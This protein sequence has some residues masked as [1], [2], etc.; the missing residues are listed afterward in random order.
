MRFRVASRVHDLVARPALRSCQRRTT[1]CR[2]VVGVGETLVINRAWT[3]SPICQREG[4]FAW[5]SPHT[6][7]ASP[8]RLRLAISLKEP[9]LERVALSRREWP[10]CSSLARR[11]SRLHQHPCFLQVPSV[12]LAGHRH[13]AILLGREPACSWDARFP[14]VAHHPHGDHCP[15]SSWFAAV[16][17]SR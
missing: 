17:S 8:S 14:C 11:A 16:P 15:V 12:Q 9:P 2:G 10:D 5:R 6:A 3:V 13:A 7:G 1:S 4:D